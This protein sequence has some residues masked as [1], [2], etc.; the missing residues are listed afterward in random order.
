MRLSPS[1]LRDVHSTFGSAEMLVRRRRATYSAVLELVA[2]A[3]DDMSSDVL[4]SPAV[5]AHLGQIIDGVEYRPEAMTPL[6]RIAN[7]AAGITSGVSRTCV[8]GDTE[9][10]A[11]L[12]DAVRNIASE[13]PATIDRSG[14]IQL[15]LDGDPGFDT[16][17]RIVVD[18]L[19]LAM[20]LCPELADDLLPHVALFA[21]LAEGECARQLGSASIRDFPGL[22]VVPQPGSALEVAEAL[23]HEGAHQKF[24]DLGLVRSI[25]N[26]KFCEAP[27][28]GSSWAPRTA[29]RWPLEQCVAAFHAYTCL[30]TFYESV[31]ASDLGQPLHEFSLLPVAGERAAELGTWL[32]RNVQ[33]LGPDG[34]VFVSRLTR[35]REP[36]DDAPIVDV[37]P[38]EAL[39]S[40]VRVCDEWT[41]FAQKADRVELYWVPS[42]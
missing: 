3:A 15:L 1:D 19:E 20:K 17:S 25:F 5:R 24:F 33:F 9:A 30:A 18:G 7:R 31:S 36:V 38:D 23:V 13:L 29:P 4:D 27:F 22:V 41:L 10:R 21:V 32:S 2:G 16:A 39:T 12:A 42:R 34:R 28:F 37:K 26:E 11:L 14:E 8:V 35:A 40:V 6:S